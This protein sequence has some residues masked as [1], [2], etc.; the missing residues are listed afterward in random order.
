MKFLLTFLILLGFWV[1]LSGKFDVWHLCW[2]VGS[3]AVV[4]LL[5]SDLLFKGPLGIGERIGEVLR[6]LAYIPW[7]LKEIFLA[8]LHVA[9][10]AWHPRMRELI[11]PRVIR[12]RTRLK[13]D[14]SRVTFANSITLT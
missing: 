13:K 1:V 4:S 6:F 11:D 3:A 2:G 8:G 14:L 10:L 12:F 5:G 9:Y 7:L